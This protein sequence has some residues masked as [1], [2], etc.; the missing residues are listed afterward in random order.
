M[1]RLKSRKLIEKLFSE[2]KV[3][4]QF[5]IRAIVIF[6]GQPGRDEEKSSLQAGFTVSTR[7]FKKA[8]HRNRIKRLMRETFRLQQAEL[9]KSVEDS[10]KGLA[11]FFIFT[12]KEI[13]DYPL[14]FKKMESVLRKITDYW[15]E[16]TQ[17]HS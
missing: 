5:P 7:N 9:I 11:V 17:N 12:G 8:V 1:E 16:T 10:E 6:S 15:N 2:G 14:V 13:P 3:F 4:Q